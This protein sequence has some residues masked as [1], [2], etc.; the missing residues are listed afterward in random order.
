MKAL[1]SLGENS[2]ADETTPRDS[3]ATRM[4]GRFVDEGGETWYRID[5]Y[6]PLSPFFV[7]LAGDSD[8]WAFVS[9]AGSLAA[10]RRDAAQSIEPWCTYG[11]GGFMPR[12]HR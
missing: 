12:R 9:T 10:G 1:S 11:A 3:T 5:D 7:A 2:A 4:R 6:D 8:L